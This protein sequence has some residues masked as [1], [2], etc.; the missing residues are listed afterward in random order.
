MEAA[1]EKAKAHAEKLVCAANQ[2]VCQKKDELDKKYAKLN[3]FEEAM[4]Q[5]KK[6]TFHFSEDTENFAP[7]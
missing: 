7:V 3:R 1:L 6:Q 5:A 4:I 2:L